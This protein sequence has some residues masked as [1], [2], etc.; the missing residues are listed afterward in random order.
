MRLQYALFCQSVEDAGADGWTLRGVPKDGMIIEVPWD[1]SGERP[2]KAEF[3]IQ[4]FIGFVECDLEPHQLSVVG[5]RGRQTKAPCRP[6]LSAGTGGRRAEGAAEPG[7][8]RQDHPDDVSPPEGATIS[9]RHPHL[10]P[11]PS[12]WRPWDGGGLG[13]G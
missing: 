12:H 5:H 1:G 10:N 4:L 2:S 8:H 9:F 6:Y 3:R 11:P 7:S 13:W